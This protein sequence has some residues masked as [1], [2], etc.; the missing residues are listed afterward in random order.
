MICP[1]LMLNSEAQTTAIVATAGF[2]GAS[3]ENQELR[4]LLEAERRKEAAERSLT[5]ARQPVRET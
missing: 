2:E 5:C 3:V 4:R 1:L